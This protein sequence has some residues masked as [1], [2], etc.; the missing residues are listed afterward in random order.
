ME[1]QIPRACRK[2]NSS[3]TPENT[4]QQGLYFV[5]YV[6]KNLPLK[7]VLQHLL[8]QRNTALNHKL[9][10]GPI[11]SLEIGECL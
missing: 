3:E 7:R 11:K 1:A 8:G 6:Y 9:L 5:I 4:T 10:L 2:D